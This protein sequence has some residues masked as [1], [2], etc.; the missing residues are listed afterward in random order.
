[1][2]TPESITVSLD[3]ARK[4]KNAG[5]LQSESHFI[6]IH[7]DADTK[8]WSRWNTGGEPRGGY[9]DGSM[10]WAAPTAEEILRR[11]PAEVDDESLYVSSQR[12]NGLWVVYYGVHGERHQHLDDTLANA[13]AAMYCYLA[14]QK[15]LP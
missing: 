13:A 5:W 3:M 11:L 7:S 12:Y 8:L 2:T 9:I 1:M 15:L 14:E 4:L 6:F 10:S